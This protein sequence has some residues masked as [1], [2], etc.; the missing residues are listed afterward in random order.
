M[1]LVR[2]AD[3]LES[4]S[5]QTKKLVQHQGRVHKLAV[6]PGSSR[7][8]MSCGEDGIVRRFD[9]RD[10]NNKNMFKCHGLT[11][12]SRRKRHPVRLNCI[13]VNTRNSNY[14]AVGG[15]DKY[16]RVYDIRKM[17]WDERDSDD[18]HVEALFPAH[19]KNKGPLH[20]TALAYSNQEELLVSYSDE[21]IYLFEKDMQPVSASSSNMP[22]G[23]NIVAK[24]AQVYKGHRNAQTIKGVSFLGP[25]SEYVVSGSDCGNIF[26]WKKKGGELI[27]LFKG[28]NQ[29]VNCLEPHPHVTFLATS[30]LDHTAKIW[31][32]LSEDYVPLPDNAE[33]IMKSNQRGR[34][35]GFQRLSDI[36]H[37][38]R[39][40]RRHAQPV[41][42]S[43][44]SRRDARDAGSGE[45]EDDSEDDGSVV[46]GYVMVLH[47]RV[48]DESDHEEEEEDQQYSV[49][50]CAII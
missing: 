9:L 13:V 43:W 19:L 26:I 39:L 28:D 10:P 22:V 16:A 37:I 30:G 21:Q 20:V 27:S 12:I 7:I 31:A 40:Q 38:M 32:P 17:Q 8:F 47:G 42:A 11:G 24:E 49:N 44:Y 14:F 1:E 33:K 3:I 41:V 18:N 29:V 6:E 2:Q 50:E 25:N 4:G 48:D 34:E 36:I 5:V 46:N 15:S 35:E 23:A 45:G